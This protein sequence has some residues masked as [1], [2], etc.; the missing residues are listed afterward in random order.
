M[1]HLKGKVTHLKHIGIG[2]LRV[3]DDNRLAATEG[4]GDR[5]L[6]CVQYCFAAVWRLDDIVLGAANTIGLW[7]PVQ[8][9]FAAAPPTLSRGQVAVVTVK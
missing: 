8:H 6:T 4:I 1:K 3:L 5:V 2:V 9:E 7:S